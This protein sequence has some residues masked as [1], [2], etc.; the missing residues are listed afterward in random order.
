[1]ECSLTTVC[2]L[3][4][5]AAASSG[6]GT[7]AVS[8]SIP[9]HSIPLQEWIPSQEWSSGKNAGGEQMKHVGVDTERQ[10]DEGKVRVA[11]SDFAGLISAQTRRASLRDGSQGIVS[12]PSS[13]W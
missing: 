10:R 2:A 7:G 1:M 3:E 8:R 6:A 4:L 9:A 13:F 12:S 5:R 11:R